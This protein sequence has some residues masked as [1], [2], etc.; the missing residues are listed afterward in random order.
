VKH[1]LR[2]LIFAVGMLGAAFQWAHRRLPSRW[3]PRVGGVRDRCV[4]EEDRIQW[5]GSR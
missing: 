1:G 5:H 3:R 2:L 4:R